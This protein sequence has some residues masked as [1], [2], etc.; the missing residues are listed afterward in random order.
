[1][2]RLQTLLHFIFRLLPQSIR[3]HCKDLFLMAQSVDIILAICRSLLLPTAPPSAPLSE[4]RQRKFYINWQRWAID[5]L[6]G[7]GSDHDVVSAW[8]RS[9]IEI[10]LQTASELRRKLWL[11]DEFI[12]NSLS[13]SNGNF[14]LGHDALVSP[15]CAALSFFAEAKTV[16][17]KRLDSEAQFAGLRPFDDFLQTLKRRFSDFPH[18]LE[19]LVTSKNVRRLTK[20]P[21][22]FTF[23]SDFLQNLNFWPVYETENRMPVWKTTLFEGFVHLLGKYLTLRLKSATDGAEDRLTNADKLDFLESLWADD[24]LTLGRFHFVTNC[25]RSAPLRELEENGHLR[26]FHEIFV[27]HWHKFREDGRLHFTQSFLTQ[28]ARQSLVHHSVQLDKLL[29]VH[30]TRENLL[31]DQLRFVLNITSLNSFWTREHSLHELLDTEGDVEKRSTEFFARQFWPLR[32]LLDQHLYQQL[33]AVSVRLRRI[34]HA[35]LLVMDSI[36]LSHRREGRFRRQWP[37]GAIPFVTDDL[38]ERLRRALGTR[39]MRQLQ[40]LFQLL[41]IHFSSLNSVCVRALVENAEKQ[42]NDD[43]NIHLND[44]L[45]VVQE[46]K[47]ALTSLLCFIEDLFREPIDELIQIGNAFSNPSTVSSFDGFDISDNGS[48][49]QDGDDRLEDPEHNFIKTTDKH[50]PAITCSSSRCTQTDN[51]ALSL[52]ICYKSCRFTAQ[53]VPDEERRVNSQ[54][55]GVS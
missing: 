13:Y 7:G 16:A 38:K 44:S 14:L 43:E 18:F 6:Y 28:L 25:E 12:A 45:E 53:P 46:W 39:L 49:A 21:P 8:H 32:V 37:T 33:F 24:E 52:M 54:R 35:L 15:V 48:N 5:R 41:F 11:I 3:C 19:Q 55:H 20:Q 23:W 9:Q 4:D 42:R 22:I 51:T 10:T 1:M 40:S 27:A 31:K 2:I 30:L 29:L 36:A 47:N 50:I 17:G 34:Q 26:P